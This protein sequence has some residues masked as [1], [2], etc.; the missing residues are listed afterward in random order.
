M[1]AVVRERA[2]GNVCVGHGA[3]I[4]RASSDAAMSKRG[5]YGG[6]SFERNGA[7]SNRG[8]RNNGWLDFES[9]PMGVG[10]SRLA[11]RCRVRDGCYRGY[12]EGSY[13]I[14]KIFSDDYE[15]SVSQT[16]VDM[17]L[18]A[19]QLAKEFNRECQPTKNGDSCNVHIR[20]AALGFFMEDRTFY[21]PRGRRLHVEQYEDFLLEREIRGSFEK[22]NSNSGWSSGCD[23]ILDAFSHWTWVHTGGEKLVCD[24]QGHREEDDGLPHKGERN[25]YLLTDPAICT[26]CHEYGESDTGQSGIDGFFAHHVCNHWCRKLDID[27][28]RPQYAC[29]SIPRRQSTS[30]HSLLR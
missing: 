20:D 25:Y 4:G 7:D 18:D 14:V 2:A 29:A 17:Q 23:P 12:T 13:C 30:Y 15:L 8:G 3:L 24:L 10:E 19:M 27:Y 21:N 6:S 1:F 5:R 9:H 16:D 26:P 22:F 28:E 11:Y